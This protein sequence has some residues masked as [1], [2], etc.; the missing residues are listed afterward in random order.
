MEQIETVDLATPSQPR[1]IFITGTMIRQIVRNPVYRGIVRV[2]VQN[3]DIAPGAPVNAEWEEFKGRHEPTVSEDTWFR[4]NRMLPPNPKT[5]SSI[6]RKAKIHSMGLLQGLLSCGCCNAA[7]CP[8]A[9]SRAR[10]TGEK[11]WYYRCSQKAKGASLS[12]CTTRQ[13]S[14]TAI[15]TAIVVL[16]QAVEAN[17][18][19]L[20]RMGYDPTTRKREAEIA[21]CRAEILQLDASLEQ[22][23]REISN[24]IGFIQR[25]ESEVLTADAMTKAQE[26]KVAS[27]NLEHQ[28]IQQETR[29]HKLSGKTPQVSELGAAFGPVAKALQFSNHAQKYEILH[30]IIKNIT[31]RRV[32]IGGTDSLRSASAT[33]TFR[34]AIEV[35][36]DALLKFG[37]TDFESVQTVK[38]YSNVV[39][40]VTFEVHSNAKEQKVILLEQGYSCVAAKFEVPEVANPSEP[41]H[42]NENPIQRA[43]RWKTLISIER[44]TAVAI[45]KRENISEGLIS[46]YLA[47]LNLPQLIVDFM[48]DGRDRGL[49]KAISMRELQRL[50]PLENNDAVTWFHARIAGVPLQDSLPLNS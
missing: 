1:Q 17:S 42:H 12:S 41:T 49:K 40:K 14:G 30:Q 7:M 6:Q 21:G 31:L 10:K 32:S 50:L 8:G 13:I 46:Q 22:T 34:M 3:R 28:R 33:R 25:G 44:Q 26:L 39:L 19:I 2:K 37:K 16:M 35:K 18:A 29:L 11:H 45:A 27:A 15:E 47:L 24:L 20:V 23:H 5:G 48:K 4:A 43:V 9:A 38:G 36:T